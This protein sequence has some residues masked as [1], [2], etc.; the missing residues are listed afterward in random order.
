MSEV[1]QAVKNLLSNSKKLNTVAFDFD[2][3]LVFTGEVHYRCYQQAIQELDL[4]SKFNSTI[5]W[6]DINLGFNV[7]AEKMGYDLEEFAAINSRKTAIFSRVEDFSLNPVALDI[8]NHAIELDYETAILTNA[9]RKT[10]N[11]VCNS[12]NFDYNSY[13]TKVVTR[14][15]VKNKKPH[16]EMSKK[17]LESFYITADNVL[18]IGDDSK[19][20]MIFALNSGFHYAII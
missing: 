12:L 16:N 13:F 2:N 8:L 10:L 7:V 9:S 20:D 18:Y 17:I 6:D 1:L 3:T 4:L 11:H 15:D 19:H 14:D 5:Y